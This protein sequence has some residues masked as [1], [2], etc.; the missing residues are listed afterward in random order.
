[1][2]TKGSVEPYQDKVTCDNL[3]YFQL[4][5]FGT[6]SF[7]RTIVSSSSQKLVSTDA[8]AVMSHAETICHGFS[9]SDVNRRQSEQLHRCH[10]H[11][12]ACSCV[13]CA[14]RADVCYRSVRSCRLV[15]PCCMCAPC[16]SVGTCEIVQCYRL[17]VPRCLFRLC[18]RCTLSRLCL[19]CACSFVHVAYVVL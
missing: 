5:S 14:Y 18:V 1:M 2:K 4:C 3:I 17:L 8:V 10:Q 15:L 7:G 9:F 13:P 12:C 16:T 6:S 11:A 19:L